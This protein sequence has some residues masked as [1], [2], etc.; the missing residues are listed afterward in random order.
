MHKLLTPLF[1][2]IISFSLFSQQ[3]KRLAL[4][5]GNSAYEKGELNN[6]VNDAK[7][8]AKTLDS[9][10]FEVIEAYDVPSRR[11]LL[12]VVSLFGKK[13]ISPWEFVQ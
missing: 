11:E 9:L 13:L 2:L 10:D 5:I 12:N 6:P 8:I 3:E 1:C 4:V 7:L